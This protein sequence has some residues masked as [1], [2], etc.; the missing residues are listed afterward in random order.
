M[1][2]GK[3]VK[4]SEEVVSGVNATVSEQTLGALLR[5]PYEILAATVY[6][7]LARSGF[8]EIRPAHSAVF[9]HI[10]PEGSWI[11][12]LAEK[13]QMT[14]QSMSYLVDYLHEHGFV[15]FRAD[16]S[17]RRAKCVHL[18]DKGLRVQRAAVEIS[19]QVEQELVDVVGAEGMKQLRTLL[20]KLNEALQTTSKSA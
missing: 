13:N 7:E 18:T 15:E 11:V 3:K 10:A 1:S 17:D 12:E 5:G 9:R 6:G 16:P 8:S 4:V 19:R 14:K 2:N 20:A